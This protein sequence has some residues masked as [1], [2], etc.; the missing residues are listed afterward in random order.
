[1]SRTEFAGTLKGNRPVKFHHS[2]QISVCRS[3]YFLTEYKRAMT[4]LMTMPPSGRCYAIT[5]SVCN[6]YFRHSEMN[7]TEWFRIYRMFS[8]PVE[9][10]ALFD[11]SNIRTDQSKPVG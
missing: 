5:H 4:I 3:E 8:A 2:L 7:A 1:M 6:K 9:R 10:L 11:W